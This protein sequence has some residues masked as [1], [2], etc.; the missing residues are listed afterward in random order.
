VKIG[1][2]VCMCPWA[3]HLM[4]LPLQVVRLV[5]TSGSWL[6][7][8]KRH[9][10]VSWWRQLGKLKKKSNLHYTHLIPF[11][12]SWVSGAYLCSFVPGPIQQCCSIG[13][14]LATCGRFDRLGI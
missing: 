14:S 5:V 13:E 10:A 3:K 6:K 4:K 7:D 2:Q 9:F 11:R 12:V 1:W 8:H